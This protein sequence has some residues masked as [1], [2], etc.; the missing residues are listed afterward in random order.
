M[1]HTDQPPAPIPATPAALAEAVT[2]SGDILKDIELSRLPLST[3]V[4]KTLRL[5]RL[6]ND[7]EYQ[8]IFEWESGG[9]PSGP[10]GVS[11]TTG[12]AGKQAGRAF[13]KRSSPQEDTKEHMYMSSIEEIEHTINMGKTSLESAHAGHVNERSII[14]RDM[15]LASG[16]L[17]SRRT[18]IYSY[19]ARN[20]YELRLAG[21]AD[22]LFG[23]IRSS[24]DASLGLLV[25]DSIRKLT[26]VYDNL[27]SDNPEDWANAT[28]SCRRVLQDLADAVFPAKGEPRLKDVD[29]RKKEIELGPDQYINRLMCYIEDS[30]DS[31]RFIEIVGSHL[32]YI[33]DRIDSIF[34]AAQKGSHSTVTR[35]EADRCVVYTY[36]LVGDILSLG[37]HQTLTTQLGAVHETT[38]ESGG[39]IE[40]VPDEN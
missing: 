8:K 21:V 14:R 25:P 37:P 27:K 23:R 39:D 16:R 5:A 7:F 30:S 36:L 11:Y 18:L 34:R 32:R 15:K 28:H 13:S 9:Y 26:A 6:L 33:G 19:A 35:E 40:I 4:L 29:G 24:V 31:T 10:A 38:P 12:L 2:L 3:V 22:D 17:A 20:H 1:A